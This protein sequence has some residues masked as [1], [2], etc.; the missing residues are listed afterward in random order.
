MVIPL[1]ILLLESPLR[2]KSEDEG[3]AD[4]LVLLRTDR[5]RTVID[6]PLRAIPGDQNGVVGQ[7]D[8]TPFSQGPRSGVLNG[9][10]GTSNH[11]AENGFEPLTDCRISSPARQLFRNWV[12]RRDLA[13]P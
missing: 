3:T 13:L 4:D 7:P 1:Q 6:R 10:T 9:F 11:D 2:R 12:E 5:R 8:Q